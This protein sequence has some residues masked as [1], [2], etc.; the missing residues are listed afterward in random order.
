MLKRIN[1][2]LKG[3]LSLKRY[4]HTIRVVET[5]KKIA[6][7]Y[8]VDQQKVKLAALCH[9]LTKERPKSWQLNILHKYGVKDEMLLTVAPIMHAYTASVYIQEKYLITDE[10]VIEAI[11]FHT[12][13]NEQMGDVAKVVY[14]ADYIE[15]D[16]TQSGVHQ[17]RMM[18]N[19]SS[20]DEIVLKIIE[21]EFKYFEEVNKQKHPDTIKL[22][23]KLK[24][25]RTP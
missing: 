4:E 19:K 20:L 16:R 21:N 24:G 12:I 9:D 22:Y 10:E 15:P 14:I 7:Y 18:I 11:R 8:H 1:E 6:K 23:N 13:G 17:I 2:D 3:E 5:A 25:I